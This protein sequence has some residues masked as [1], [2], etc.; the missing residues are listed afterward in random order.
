MNPDFSA[1]LLKTSDFIAAHRHERP[2]AVAL[3]LANQGEK[4]GFDKEASAFIVRQIEGWQ[5]LSAKV[6]QWTEIPSLIYPPRLSLEQ[7]SSQTAAEHKAQLVEEIVNNH[8]TS[9]APFTTMIDLTGGLG[10]DFSFLAPLFLEATYVEQREELVQLA[11]HNF[12]LLGLSH[13]NCLCGDGVT[14]LST[15]KSVDL[16]YL[17][18]ARRDENGRKTVRIEDCT[19][20]VLELLPQ[21]REKARCLLVKLSPMLDVHQAI[22]ALGCVTEAH[23][24]AVEGEC[25]EILLLCDLQM[26]Q[27]QQSSGPTSPSNEKPQTATRWICTSEKGTFAFTQQ[28]EQTALCPMATQIEGFL[29]EP[30]AAVMK[31][32]G[33]KTFG[34]RFG[35]QKLHPNTQLYVGAQADLTLPARCFRIVEV[36]GFQKKALRSISNLKKANLT[37]RNFPNSVAELRK[38]LK[39][40]EGGNH[41]LF[42]CTTAQDEKVIIVTEK[43][44]TAAT[45]AR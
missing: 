31:A 15:M 23:V 14:H 26:L 45:C 9:E 13:A 18:P 42:A 11:R 28:E 27:V 1:L 43:V 21:L 44:T 8:K 32:G 19:P 30:D 20:N 40:A 7:C 22:T 6:P 38:R 2:E 10:V 16:V 37:V 29:Y 5:K 36:V 12:P 3:V 4:L 24:V 34:V 39:L 35:L 41:Y 17:D 25:K 33:Y